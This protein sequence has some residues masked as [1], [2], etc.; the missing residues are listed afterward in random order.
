MDQATYDTPIKSDHRLILL[1]LIIFDL[2]AA[3]LLLKL[4]L[5]ITLAI[6]L[7]TGLLIYIVIRPIGVIYFLIILSFFS[8]FVIYQSSELNIIRIV[9]TSS[10]VSL[11]LFRI[12]LET[13]TIQLPETK[14]IIPYAVFTIYV[15]CTIF[16]AFNPIKVLNGL[17]HLTYYFI[18]FITVYNLFDFH[19]HAN[20][21]ITAIL[22]IFSL[23]STYVL[24]TS[25]IG[26]AKAGFLGINPNQFVMQ[27]IIGFGFG[28]YTLLLNT[29]CKIKFLALVTIFLCILTIIATGSRGGWLAFLVFTMVFLWLSGKKKLVMLGMVGLAAA[30]LFLIINLTEYF[31]LMKQTRILA[32]L[33]GRPELWKGGLKVILAYPVFGVGMLSVGEVLRYY[34]DMANPLIPIFTHLPVL[35]GKLHNGY[36]QALAE[37]G[38]FGFIIIIWLNFTFVKY[39]LQNLKQ[40]IDYTMKVT[41]AFGLAIVLAD[42]C[43]ALYES[44]IP[45]GIISSRIL[46]LVTLAIL[47]KSLDQKK[48]EAETSVKI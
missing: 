40:S 36:L 32:G 1:S 18:I 47:V 21:I 8:M 37:F 25:G 14:L 39:L 31:D 26:I 42:F 10:L 29:D 27:I 48:T 45:F 23:L 9:F 12:Y 19:K 43:R 2:I 33:T 46:V 30:A 38:I 24:L 13:K 35:T 4:S 15:L 28:L 5:E 44:I 16:L 20:R 11:I 17:I 22:L 3:L 41:S 6:V 34:V 7:I